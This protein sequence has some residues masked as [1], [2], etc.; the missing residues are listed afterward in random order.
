M[1]KKYAAWNPLSSKSVIQNRR[2]DKGFPKQ[3]K[4]AGIHHHPTRPTRDPKGD[5]VNEM[6]QGPQSTRDITTSKK[7]T[8][9]TMT[10]AHIFQ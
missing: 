7:P 3:T 9:I 2:R 6:L 5:T 4:T 8:D 10:L 1:Q